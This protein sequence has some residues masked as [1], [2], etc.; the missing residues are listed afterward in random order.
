MNIKRIELNETLLTWY[1]DGFATWSYRGANDGEDGIFGGSFHYI[2]DIEELSDNEFQVYI[3][4]GSADEDLAMAELNN[5]LE[6]L[7]LIAENNDGLI[8]I[9]GC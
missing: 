2:S 8:K 3:D 7:N 5:R 9:K 1:N 6:K 4:F